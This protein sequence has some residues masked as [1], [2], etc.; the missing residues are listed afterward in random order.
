M[1]IYRFVRHSANSMECILD[2]N[3]IRYCRSMPHRLARRT[4]NDSAHTR[5]MRRNFVYRQ[6]AFGPVDMSTPRPRFRN[7][8]QYK[9]V[10]ILREVSGMYGFES[11]SYLASKPPQ[12]RLFGMRVAE[13]RLDDHHRLWLHVRHQ[14]VH[15]ANS[16]ILAVLQA[17]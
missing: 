14:L 17:K 13:A 6:V 8:Q 7:T 2:L 11:F 15:P 3:L 4:Y 1:L 5:A 10:S 9:S 16:S 12:Y